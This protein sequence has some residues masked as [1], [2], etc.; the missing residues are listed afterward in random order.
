[1]QGEALAW[2]SGLVPDTNVYFA[3]NGETGVNQWE[4]RPFDS[5]VVQRSVRFPVSLVRLGGM[6]AAVSAGEGG[7]GH[8]FAAKADQPSVFDQAADAFVPIDGAAALSANVPYAQALNLWRDQLA[9]MIDPA[10]QGTAL[11]S[12][13][14]QSRESGILTNATAYIAVESHAQWKML[15]EAERKKLKASQHMELGETSTSVIPE[16]STALLLAFAG[17]VFGLRRRRR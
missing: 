1:M 15:E 8:L 2:M 17:S 7:V 11:G 3:W 14:L 9:A 16:P 10:G 13:V 5:N 12:L 4:S 6:N